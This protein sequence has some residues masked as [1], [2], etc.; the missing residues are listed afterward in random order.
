ME[1]KKR[2][3]DVVQRTPFFW[4]HDKRA[5]VFRS[6]FPFISFGHVWARYFI[7]AATQQGNNTA[8]SNRQQHSKNE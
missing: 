7:Q 6:V 2:K 3:R 5:S 8:I 4:T 1:K